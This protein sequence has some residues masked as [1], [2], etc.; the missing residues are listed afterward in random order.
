MELK[1]VSKLNAGQLT[2]LLIVPYGI[3]TFTKCSFSHLL[4]ELLIVPY[5]IE[6]DIRLRNNQNPDSF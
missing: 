2:Q 3:E 1:H 5:G 4:T 6:T